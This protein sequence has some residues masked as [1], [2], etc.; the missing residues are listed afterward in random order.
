MPLR[1]ARPDLWGTWVADHPGLPGSFPSC[2]FQF[3]LSWKSLNGSPSNG[4]GWPV[5]RPGGGVRDSRL[6]CRRPARAPRPGVAPTPTR[7]MRGTLP[8]CRAHCRGRGNYSGFN[9]CC[10][11]SRSTAPQPR[12]PNSKF[13]LFQSLLSF[14][15]LIAGICWTT[16]LSYHFS[17]TIF[18]VLCRQFRREENELTPFC[19]PGIFPGEHEG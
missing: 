12:I 8:H 18:H 10:H 2:L 9:T 17:L 13:P 1:R 5:L 4:G 15:A 19:S 11:G 16:G 6:Q 14:R 7:R 3:L